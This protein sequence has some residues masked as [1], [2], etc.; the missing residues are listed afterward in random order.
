M[1][2]HWGKEDTN[3][4]VNFINKKGRDIKLIAKEFGDTYSKRMI[5]NKLGSLRKYEQK[6]E[7]EGLP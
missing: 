4:L 7:R 6:A 1:G 2:K 5:Y 3:R